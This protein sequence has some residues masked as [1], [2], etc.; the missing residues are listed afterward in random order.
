MPEEFNQHAVN[1]EGLVANPRRT[2]FGSGS[3]GFFHERPHLGLL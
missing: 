2:R 3:S 1:H